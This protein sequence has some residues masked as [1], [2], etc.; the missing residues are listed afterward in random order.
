MCKYNNYNRVLTSCL[1]QNEENTGKQESHFY[2]LTHYS[3]YFRHERAL[4]E[5]IPNSGTEP[6]PEWVSGPPSLLLT[7]GDRISDHET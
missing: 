4:E 5:Q 3:E 1:R 7:W 2:V 6:G